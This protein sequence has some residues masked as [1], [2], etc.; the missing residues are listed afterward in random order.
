MLCY[1]RGGE[2]TLLP[3]MRGRRGKL[4]DSGWTGSLCMENLIL[5]TEL[6]EKVD[7]NKKISVMHDRE[8]GSFIRWK[9]GN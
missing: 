5:M 2:T 1:L 3:S 4:R 7:R 9:M 6:G 8:G